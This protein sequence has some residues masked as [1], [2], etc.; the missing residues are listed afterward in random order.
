MHTLVCKQAEGML[1]C[2]LVVGMLVEGMLVEGML[3]VGML[4]CTLVLVGGTLVCKAVGKLVCT[5]VAGKEV[6][7]AG[8]QVGMA[9]RK[10][11][12]YRS[13]C[14]SNL[15][16]REL[17]RSKRASQLTS[18]VFFSLKTPIFS[19]LGD[20]SVLNFNFSNVSFEICPNLLAKY[21]AMVFARMLDL[22]APVPFPIDNLL[23]C[24]KRATCL[25]LRHPIFSLFNLT[26]NCYG[27]S[28][29]GP[30]NGVLDSK[31]RVLALDSISKHMAMGMV[32][33]MDR[34]IRSSSSKPW[35]LV[36]EQ[37]NVS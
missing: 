18:L 5:L 17:L 23:V 10:Q 21:W 13:T 4:V 14:Q 27:R 1:V 6:V 37:I 30:K 7:P 33:R 32:C 22:L 19:V 15:P 36:R 24:L 3:V 8:I 34:Y 20:F 28:M 35:L 16:T 26:S 11:E 2:K 25:S 31:Q 12:Q 29:S 9:V